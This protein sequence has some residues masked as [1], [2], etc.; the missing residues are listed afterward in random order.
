VLGVLLAR[1]G[2]PLPE[3]RIRALARLRAPA[4]E[5]LLTETAE[6]LSRQLQTPV[7]V[8]TAPES[9]ALKRMIATTPDRQHWDRAADA[10]AA[11][12][13]AA[14]ASRYQDAAIA[15]WGNRPAAI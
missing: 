2:E 11:L 13:D 1:L 7:P 3:P 9:Q 10:F 8:W 14:A 5:S 12:G 4:L 6:A 15:I